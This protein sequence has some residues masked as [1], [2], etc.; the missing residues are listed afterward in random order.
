MTPLQKT[1]PS[2]HAAWPL[3]P[4]PEQKIQAE[5]KILEAAYADAASSPEKALAFLKDIGLL[6]ENGD[7]AAPY[8]D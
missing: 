1:T 3:P 7:L 6:D 2:Q 4:T 5:M 8:R